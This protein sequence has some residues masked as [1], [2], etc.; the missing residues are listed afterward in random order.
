MTD[1]RNPSSTELQT[2]D[3][4]FVTP[5]EAQ[6][7][8]DAAIDALPRGAFARALATAARLAEANTG[9]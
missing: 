4:A 8:E 7:M 2:E 9:D 1:T 5:E 3:F 6:R